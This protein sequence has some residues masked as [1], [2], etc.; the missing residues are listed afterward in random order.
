MGSLLALALAL[1]AP[2]QADLDLVFLL[3]TTGSMSGEI[4]EAKNQVRSISEALAEARP[5]ERVRIGVVAYRDQGEEYVTQVSDLTTDVEVTFAALARL[6]ASGG[7]DAPEDVLAGIQAT[8]DQISWDPDP[9][10]ERQAF[11]IG[12]APA[13]LGYDEHPDLDVILERAATERIVIHAIG[14]RSLSRK[15]IEQYRRIAYGTEGQ[16]HHIGRVQTG[17]G[18]LAEAMISSLTDEAE[19]GPRTPIAVYRSASAPAPAPAELG[20]RSLGVRLGE[21]ADARHR[22][23]WGETACLLTVLR[24]EGVGGGEPVVSRTED[25]LYVELPVGPGEGAVEHYELETCLPRTTPVHV[26]LT[27]VN[28]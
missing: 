6:K 15:G 20:T 5:Q 18:G 10:V 25:A 9:S 19:A 16:Y 13:H 22:E 1:C 7:G 21:W 17:D 4:R 27:Q 8:I 3:D 24:P 12:D 14:C 28:P 11:L 2:A 26:A 23:D